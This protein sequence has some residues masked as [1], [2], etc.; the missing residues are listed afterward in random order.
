MK[1]TTRNLL[2]ELFIGAI[3]VL[4]FGLAVAG[5]LHRP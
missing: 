1:E 4:M 2:F 5:I 3:V